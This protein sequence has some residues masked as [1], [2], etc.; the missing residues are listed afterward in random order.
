MTQTR[1]SGFTTK[2]LFNVG[3]ATP[4]KNVS[5]QT[6]TISAVCVATKADGELAGYMKDDKGAI[7]A[8]ISNSV[9][10]QLQ[11]LAELV[12]E[13]GAQGVKV[14]ERTSNA[15]RTYFMLELV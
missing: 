10:D 5:G 8:T 13:S 4:L 1:T 15:G 2:D 7:Y 14:L 3:S 9:I 12:E 6:L 11:A